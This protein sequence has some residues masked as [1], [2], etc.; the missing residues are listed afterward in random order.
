MQMLEK[1]FRILN[2]A[3]KEGVDAIAMVLSVERKVTY[4]T[5]SLPNHY[6]PFPYPTT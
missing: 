2:F 1:K 4:T 3:T 6:F 5:F